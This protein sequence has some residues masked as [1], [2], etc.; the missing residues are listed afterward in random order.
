MSKSLALRHWV[1]R[2]E[3]PLAA[4]IYTSVHWL[5]NASFPSIPPVHKPLYYLHC[6]TRDLWRNMLRIFYY[7][8]MFQ[9][10]LTRPA[11]ELFLES[12]MPLVLGPLQITIGEHSHIFGSTTFTGRGNGKI[13]PELIIGRNCGIGWQVTIAVGTKVV[14]G[15][16]VRVTN[17]C[18][19]AGYPGH[20]VDPVARA[21]GDADLD[22]QAGDII[23]EDDV[24]VCTGSVVNAGV[25]IGRGTIVASG[26]VVTKDL[27]PMVLAGGIPA[28][29][30]RPLFPQEVRENLKTGTA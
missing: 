17:K 21:R 2:R 16:N 26:S 22:E 11:K 4:L 27:P 13:A 20:P 7:T 29:V 5:K 15:D 10:R 6:A 18:F 24:W 1:K 25:R 28:R 30:I 8:P 12:G 9:S 3:H 23:L 14:F 19:L